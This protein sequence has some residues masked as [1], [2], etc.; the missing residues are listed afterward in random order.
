M[1]GRAGQGSLCA[2]VDAFRASSYWRALS[3]AT[4]KQRELILAPILCEAGRERAADIAKADIV[5]GRERRAHT[6]FLANNY[7]KTLRR[8][9]G[10]A[11]EHGHLGVDP[12]IGVK[13]VPKPDNGGFRPWSEGDVE[14]YRRRWPLG[15]RQRVALDVLL[16]TGLRR[17]DATRVGQGDVENSLLR[18][19][20]EKTGTELFIPIHPDLRRALDAAPK[21]KTTWIARE[22]GEPY[23]KEGFG[24]EFGEWCREAGIRGRSA[25][26]LRKLCAVRL[27]DAG[28]S[29]GELDAFMGWK[30]G[31]GT[32]R[33]YVKTRNIRQLSQR[34]FDKVWK[35]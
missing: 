20:A 33:A 21:G 13:D 15:C 34:A 18:L 24:N 17:G 26:G 22:D 7:L 29:E 5:A 30:H 28:V 2:L 11:V 35:E 10:W 9:F 27:L 31:S 14:V 12:T 19:S 3:P 32:S 23:T 25:H 4:R 16:F 6:P 8:L 1:E